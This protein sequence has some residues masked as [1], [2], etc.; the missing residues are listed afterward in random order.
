LR[1]LLI[2]LP[3]QFTHKVK[4]KKVCVVKDP[5]KIL[6]IVR[7]ASV[8]EIKKSYRALA[9]Q[10]HPDKNPGDEEAEERFKE[11]QSAYD[12]LGDPVKRKKY[13][14]FGHLEGSASVK[15]SGAGF[16]GFQGAGFGQNFGDLFGDLFGDFFSPH[17]KNQRSRG[18]DRR[19]TLDV[20]FFMAALGGERVIK[21]PRSIGC[22]TCNTTGAKPGSSPQLCHACGGSG[23]VNMQQG[24]F[25]VKKTCTYCKGKGKMITDPCIDCEGD[26]W[27]QKEVK[28]KVKIPP[29]TESGTTLR[30]AGEGAP[31]KGGGSPG[32]LR[33]VLN[34]KSHEFFTRDGQ[35]VYCELPITIVEASLGTQLEIPTLDGKVKMKIPPGTQSGENFRL[36]GKGL[37]KNSGNGRGDQHVEIK[38]IAPVELNAKQRSMIEKLKVLDQSKHYPAREAFLGKTKKTIK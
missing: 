23:Q 30:Y 24:L 6:G 21:V 10:Y 25:S 15:G 36:R 28:L 7:T 34:V 11:A 3:K 31:G 9:H 5:Y 32:D 1:H 20:E 26:G 18:E 12:L 19:Y 35:D 29:S 17:T 13:D 16:E 38:I 2:E 8:A 27:V 4:K 14:Q 33:V 37:R 22:Q